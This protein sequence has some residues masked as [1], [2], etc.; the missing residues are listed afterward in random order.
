MASSSQKTNQAEFDASTLKLTSF[1]NAAA[2]HDG[3]LSD[4]SGAVL[5]K[6]CTPSE[7]AFYQ[8][9]ASSHTDFYELM[10]TM[11]GTLQLG[12]PSNLPGDVKLP[13]ITSTS[14][15]PAPAEEAEPELTQE[16]KDKALLHGK[17]LKTETAIVLENLEAGFSRPNVLD[18][19]LGAKLF[20][21]AT[22]K[23]DKAARL[24]KVA[25]E[26]TSGSLNY[27]IAGMK[28]WNADIGEYAIYDKFYGRQFSKEDVG[29][30]FETF[31]ESLLPSSLSGSEKEEGAGEKKKKEKISARDARSLLELFLAEITNAR[32][33]LSRSESRMYGAS[34]LIVYEGD[35]EALSE[36]LGGG[37]RDTSSLKQKEPVSK[38]EVG[39]EEEYEEEEE[40]E[41]EERKVAY[42]VKMIDFAHAEWTP[43]QGRDENVVTGLE[44]VERAM[45]E[46]IRKFF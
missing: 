5:I 26:T 15:T 42:R 3:V 9:S 11:L 22:T 44:N 24:D 40:E 46:V 31:F 27:R 23:A 37:G 18:L 7:I 45:E 25:G 6:P 2:G 10:P 41:E 4:E 8:A 43:G 38:V 33:V 28:V 34:V 12:A 32:A 13:I 21:P 14:E 16:Y 17:A 19:K 35:P 36:L 1:S 29:R 39:G 20:D 30:G